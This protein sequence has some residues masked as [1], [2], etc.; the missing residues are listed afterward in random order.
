VLQ[1]KQ[2]IVTTGGSLDCS[3]EDSAEI[4]ALDAR[5]KDIEAAE[6][7]RI[8]ITLKIPF[9]TLKAVT[10]I[11]DD[12][13]ASTPDQFERNFDHA[14]TQLTD[15]LLGLERFLTRSGSPRLELL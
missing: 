9:L 5:V 6:V 10:D 13:T 1:L 8:A 14:V 3:A 11:V 4:A 15:R 12:S 7:A 2:G